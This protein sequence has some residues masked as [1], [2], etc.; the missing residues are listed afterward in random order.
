MENIMEIKYDRFLEHYT[1]TDDALYIRK[2]KLPFSIILALYH[3]EEYEKRDPNEYCIYVRAD[4]HSRI[5]GGQYTYRM[6]IKKDHPKAKI[7]IEYLDTMIR[8]FNQYHHAKECYNYTGEFSCNFEISN[9]RSG[10][11]YKTGWGEEPKCGICGFEYPKF[12]KFSSL[13]KPAHLE[14]R[15]NYIDN[16][17]SFDEYKGINW[18]DTIICEKCLTDLLEQTNHSN[19]GISRCGSNYTTKV[20]AHGGKISKK[21]LIDLINDMCND[22]HGLDDVIDRLRECE[23]IISDKSLE[24]FHDHNGPYSTICIDFFQHQEVWVCSKGLYYSFDKNR[25]SE[26]KINKLLET[27]GKDA[28]LKAINENIDSI[29]NNGIFR[30]IILKD[31]IHYFRKT[32]DVK[33]SNNIKVDDKFSVS[34]NGLNTKGALAGG[35]L[36]GATGAVIGST[37]NSG[38][39]ISKSLT[40][41]STTDTH[42]DRK[43]ELVFSEDGKITKSAIDEN[44]YNNLCKYMPDKEYEYVL[45]H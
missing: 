45:A 35:I 23:H 11:L 18:K 14:N 34:N 5:Q 8:A 42:D 19:L 41:N 43:F 36:A 28:C 17:L 7:F 27:E 38:S 33:Y 30:K 22:I 37:I 1:I 40:V 6:G 12:G 21:N 26:D 25:M 31:D 16:P 13:I 9:I 4:L 10:V 39:S 44:L 24:W 20:M 2:T 29:K 32:G 3:E 15:T